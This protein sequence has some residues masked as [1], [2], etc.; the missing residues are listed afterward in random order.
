MESAMWTELAQFGAAGLIAWMWLMERRGAVQRETQLGEAH[1]RV[2]EQKVQLEALMSV[3][4]ENTRAVA[5]VEAGQRS[6]SGLIGGLMAGRVEAS[7]GSE[8]EG[9]RG[10]LGA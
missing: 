3:V 2:M 7:R 6:L 5:A 8:R 9:A 10:T 4:T 1:A